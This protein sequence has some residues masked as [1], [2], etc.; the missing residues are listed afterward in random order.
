M[1]KILNYNNDIIVIITITKIKIHFV[2]NL[3]S[4]FINIIE[5][6]VLYYS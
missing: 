5:F 2:N 1:W 6:Q 3:G 4:T